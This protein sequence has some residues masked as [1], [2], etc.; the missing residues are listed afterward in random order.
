MIIIVVM[1]YV[2][3]NWFVIKGIF[4]K[5]FYNDDNFLSDKIL[6]ELGLDTS[7]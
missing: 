1:I 4:S 6:D 7:S 5:K 2:L 3:F